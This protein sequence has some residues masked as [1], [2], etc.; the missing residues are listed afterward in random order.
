[1][2]RV[3]IALAIALSCS[4]A[5]AFDNKPVS[6]QIADA[7]ADVIGVSDHPQREL[8]WSKKGG[9]ASSSSPLCR[10]RSRR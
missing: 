7:I 3:L 9:A 5:P 1:M 10:R 2:L 4:A 6:T 8:K